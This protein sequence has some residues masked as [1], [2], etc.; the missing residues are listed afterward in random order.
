M[1]SDRPVSPSSYAASQPHVWR[2]ARPLVARLRFAVATVVTVAGCPQWLRRQRP[3]LFLV[4]YPHYNDP[5]PATKPAKNNLE[6][7]KKGVVI[8]RTIVFVGILQWFT[9]R[10]LLRGRHPSRLE[11]GI[12]VREEPHR[13]LASLWNAAR[14]EL[15]RELAAL[16]CRF[17]D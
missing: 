12:G 8:A 15:H 13:E 16:L 9:L 10:P 17:A 1:C 6:A 2:Q 11:N 4:R 5:E 7:G 3:R 14:E